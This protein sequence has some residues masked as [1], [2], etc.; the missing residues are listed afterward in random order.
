[1]MRIYG[2]FCGSDGEQRT[3]LYVSSDICEEKVLCAMK[4]K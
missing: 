2:V 1:M 3:K 4:F